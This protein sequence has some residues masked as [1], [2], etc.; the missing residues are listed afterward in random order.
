MASLNPL[1]RELVF[2]IVFYGP[3]LGGK[4][5]TL[6]YI[7]AT[8]KP[9]HRGKM[10]S[11]ATPTDRTL[12]F[13]FLP[14]RVPR[15]RGMSVRLQL[16]TVPGQVYYSATRKLVLS[17]SDGV[18]FVADSQGGRLD[19][20]QESLEDLNANLLEHNKVL[21]QMPHTFHWNK[22]DLSDLVPIEELDTRFNVHG[23]PS[24][25][26]VGTRGDGVFEGLERITRLV[27]RHYESELPKHEQPVMLG[28]STA[29][30]PGGG[31]ISIAEAIRGLAEAPLVSKVTP[32]H[33]MAAVRHDIGPMVLSPAPSG[34]TTALSTNPVMG[35][36][37]TTSAPFPAAPSAVPP[38]MTPLT[39]GAAES[40]LTIPPSVFATPAPPRSHALA[41][42]ALPQAPMVPTA[43]T[44]P[45][46][47]QADTPPPPPEAENVH[48]SFASRPSHHPQAIDTPSPPPIPF[49]EPGA[50]GL[51]AAPRAAAPFDPDEAFVPSPHA[52][53]PLPG[54][55][56]QSVVP[57]APQAET[58]MPPRMP[59]PNPASMP[60]HAPV[61]QGR[62]PPAMASQS[63]SVPSFAAVSLTGQPGSVPNVPTHPVPAQPARGTSG[64]AP[65]APGPVAQAGTP[66]IAPPP[67]TSHFSMAELWPE[68]ERDAVRQ[69]ET[70]IGARDAHGAVL[71]CDLL[72]T[73]LL[74]SAAAL[75]GALDAPRDPGLVALLLGLDGRRYLAFRAAVRAA[76]QKEEVSPRAALECF[77]FVLEAR[78]ARDA[79][80]R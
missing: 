33:G 35:P 30:G 1:T 50:P 22:R 49:A 29:G 6:Q 38:R 58:P 13:D 9:E 20:N 68:A 71:A 3:G 12:Y 62:L 55:L 14:L 66:T 48:T 77:T 61:S 2:K 7:H 73:R 5:T 34:R 47:Q 36:A 21:Q 31:E 39:R 32:V 53:A 56:V 42:S 72:L 37:T 43:P 51:T 70:L 24:L 80:A 19:A 45:P 15:V 26:T 16:F 41:E 76:R 8:T 27:L 25:G 23:A 78:G 59:T 28:L 10:V 75:A 67:G 52:T 60:T 54:A 40:A 57:E 74:A 69:T 63:F 18:V 79:Y 44:P 64:Q 4:T 11:L 17:G 46:P 65:A